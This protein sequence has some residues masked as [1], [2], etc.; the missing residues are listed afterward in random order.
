MLAGVGTVLTVSQLE[1][2]AELGAD[3]AVAPGMNPSVVSHAAE[4]GIPFAPGICTPSDIE[5]AVGA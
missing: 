2:V 3:F 4:I 5:R 1:K